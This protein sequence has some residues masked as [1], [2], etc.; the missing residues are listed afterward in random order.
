MF[1]SLGFVVAEALEDERPLNLPVSTHPVVTA[2]TDYTRDH[3]DHV[4]I[5]DVTRAVGVSDRTLRRLFDTHLGMSWRTYLLRARVLRSMALLAEPDRSVLEVSIAVGFDDAG[6]VRV[7]ESDR[8]RLRFPWSFR[9]SGT[10][11]RM[12]RAQAKSIICV[13]CAPHS[14]FRLNG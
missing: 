2:A 11:P 14:P 9:P 8:R 4:T 10:R 13:S 7:Q 5:G 12:R 3:L 1:R 6:A